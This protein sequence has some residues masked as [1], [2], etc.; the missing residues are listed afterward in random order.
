[1]DYL[2]SRQQQEQEQVN[3]LKA[4]K[5]T[6]IAAV[7]Q[8]REQ[9]AIHKQNMQQKEAEHNLFLR[10]KDAQ[11]VAREQ[12]I[13]S[14]KSLLQRLDQTSP[15]RLS[16][17]PEFVNLS[18]S[19]LTDVSQVQVAAML[20]EIKQLAHRDDV[21]LCDDDQIRDRYVELL[22]SNAQ[23]RDQVNSY[24]QHVEKLTQEKLSRFNQQFDA[25]SEGNTDA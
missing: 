15:T 1:V 13:A 3:A 25:E 14:V 24:G 9:L 6:L 2:L 4:Q 23:L 8:E 22:L 10:R 20:P 18:F 11:M 21:Q 5:K 16:Q 19:Q 17:Q 12:L 7:K